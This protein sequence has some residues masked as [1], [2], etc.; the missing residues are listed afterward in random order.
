M[1]D[2]LACCTQPAYAAWLVLRMTDYLACC[3]LPALA[4]WLVRYV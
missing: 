3:A 1:T 2:Y 4:A